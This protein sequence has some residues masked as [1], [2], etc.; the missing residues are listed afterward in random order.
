MIRSFRDL[1]VYQKGKDLAIEA[2]RVSR[3]LPD[4]ERYVL[5]SQ[6]RRAAMSVILNIAEG[7]GR[8]ESPKD[9]RN[10]LRQALGSTNE[11]QVLMDLVAELGYLPRSEITGIASRYEELG[12]ML[13]RL[14][15]K[16]R[17]DKAQAASEKAK[18][19]EKA[20]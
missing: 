2:Y 14:A 19:S 5:V 12:R 3:K 6:L 8:K 18:A 20:Q 1:H 7:Y 13:Y 11:V 17:D 16:W 10:F 15:E 4:E 9:F